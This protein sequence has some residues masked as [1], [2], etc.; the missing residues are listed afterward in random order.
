LCEDVVPNASHL[1]VAL[2]AIVSVTLS[3]LGPK[4][5]GNATNIIFAGIL[6]KTLPSGVTQEQVIEQLRASGDTSQ[7][8]LLSGVTLTPGLGF[9]FGLLGTV[10]LTVLASMLP[11]RSSTGFELRAERCGAVCC[12]PMS[13]R[14]PYRCAISTGCP[15]VSCS[16]VTNDIDNISQSLNNHSAK[17]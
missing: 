5:L 13:N 4:L 7:A 12:R 2:L 17:S 14:C 3:V 11:R 6:S 1:V 8:D 10:L 16:S 9:D 15:A